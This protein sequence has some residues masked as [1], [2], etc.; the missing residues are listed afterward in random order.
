MH[1]RRIQF[2]AELLQTQQA[3]KRTQYI[4]TT[5]SPI[6]PDLLPDDSLFVVCRGGRTTRVDPFSTWGLLGREK[7]I[8]QV[9]SDEQDNLPISERI[10]RGDFDA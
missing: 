1:P 7:N 9:L 10:L 2:I 6:L 8:D 4:V 5:H 3:L